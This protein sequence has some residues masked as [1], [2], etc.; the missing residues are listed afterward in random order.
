MERAESGSRA[1]VARWAI[2][3]LSTAVALVLGVALV[4]RLR[5]RGGGAPAAT[6]ETSGL[7]APAPPVSGEHPLDEATVRALFGLDHRTEYRYDPVAHILP[8]ANRRRRFPWDE[9]PLGRVLCRS[10]NLGF[11]EDRPTE[12]EKHGLRVLV[13]GDSHTQGVVDNAES[14]CHVAERELQQRLARA[15]VEV[16]NAGVGLTGPTCYLGVLQRYLELRPDAFVAVLYAGNDFV[17]E[18]ALALA[19]GRL[20]SPVVPA[21]Y[22]ETGERVHAEFEGPFS[23]GLNQAFRW[24]TFPDEVE[25]SLQ[26]ACAAYREM[27]SVCDAHGIRMLAVIL[28]TKMDVE[29]D[30]HERWQA[31]SAALQLEPGDVIRELEVARRFA[32][33]V[34]A[35]GLPCLDPTEDLRR[36]DE[37]LYWRRDYH[38]GVRGHALLGSLLARELEPLLR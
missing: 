12:V 37:V 7:R 23:Q 28:P 17:E 1:R 33:C 4:A 30:D 21:G 10:N 22:Y 24:H 16:L 34:R 11:A 14:F 9:H 19:T 35:A 31:A 20:P 5:A 25:F 26:A 27:K 29:E 8:V 18:I 13:S 38:L 36:A 2:A 3:A 32:E 15:D 6:A